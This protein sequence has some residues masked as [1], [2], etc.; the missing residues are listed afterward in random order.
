MEKEFL[1]YEGL[2]E[3]IAKIEEKYGL[4]GSLTFRGTV[5]TVS[6]LPAVAGC[7]VGDMYTV[8][9][10]GQSTPDFTDGAGQV[11]AANSEVAAV[12]TGTDT[13]PAMKWCIIGPVFDVSGKL[14]FGSAMPA[15]PSSGD[16]FLYLG[17]TAYTY[18]A[19][20]DPPSDVDPS[21][22]GWY[23]FDG[24]DYALTTDTEVQGGT[25]YFTKNEQY[26]KGVIYVY[27][28]SAWVAQSSGDIMVPISKA[29]I[30]ALFA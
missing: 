22:L 8:S 18:D 30:D 13:A 23:E 25:T 6:A 28:G 12:N 5:A 10:E 2:A 1:D 29:K 19:V 15:S 24:M 11:V 4:K 20:A 21:A 17:S 26:V 14:S 7:E 27:S 3:V 9:A 16:T